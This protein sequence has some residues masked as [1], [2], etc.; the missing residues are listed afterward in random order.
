MA[1]VKCKECGAQV[2]TKAKACPS[3]GA[4]PPKK[5]SALVWILAALFAFI[6]L[7]SCYS[8]VTGDGPPPKSP[9]AL[10]EQAK[11][12]ELDAALAKEKEAAKSLEDKKT[13]ALWAARQ[14]VTKILNDPDSAKFGK[15][16]YRDPGFV[17]GYVN[18]KNGFGG[19]TGEKGFISLGTPETTWLEGQSKDFKS[20]WNKQCASK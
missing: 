14:S 10:A 16:V 20:V 15:V 1:V 18:A 17:C 8:V 2:S 13:A 7:K 5:T 19:Y 6:F 9:E 12:K 3:C 11:S 4:K